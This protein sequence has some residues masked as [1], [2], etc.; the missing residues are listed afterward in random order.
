MMNKCIF[1]HKM[2]NIF[3]NWGLL[4]IYLLLPIQYKRYAHHIGLLQ[5]SNLDVDFDNRLNKGHSVFT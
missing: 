1:I 3:K 2:M 5:I 4:S